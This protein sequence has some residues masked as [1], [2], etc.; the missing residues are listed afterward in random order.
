MNWV[1]TLASGRAATAVLMVA[2]ALTGC[3]SSMDHLRPQA[4]EPEHTD[5]S[6]LADT[7]VVTTVAI[8]PAGYI[9]N[10][11]TA[12]NTTTGQ[13]YRFP[14]FSNPFLGTRKLPH[15]LVDIGDRSVTTHV[16]FM[17]LPPGHY[18]VY[19]VEIAHEAGFESFEF[20]KKT[21]FAFDV[22]NAT[23]HYLGNLTMVLSENLEPNRLRATRALGIVGEES[24]SG[25]LRDVRLAELRQRYSALDGVAFHHGRVVATP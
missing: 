7:L 19:E 14:Y 11:L 25:A 4:L 21:W 22:E 5:L 18:E 6:H 2:S 15:E 3:A 23:P 16:V 20:D 1:A 13:L 17:D 24:V 8:A 9:L 10:A 12:T